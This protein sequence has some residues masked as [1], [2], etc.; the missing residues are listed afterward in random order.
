MAALVYERKKM[1]YVWM[2]EADSMFAN[3]Y[4]LVEVPYVEPS[5][6]EILISS[7]WFQSLMAYQGIIC[8][9]WYDLCNMLCAICKIICMMMHVSLIAW[10]S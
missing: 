1:K 9:M 10:H 8:T 6:L 3:E 4:S 7:P 2:N 5:F